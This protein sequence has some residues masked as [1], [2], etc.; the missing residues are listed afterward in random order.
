M[1]TNF[2]TESVLWE[3]EGKLL[4]EMATTQKMANILNAFVL[5]LVTTIDHTPYLYL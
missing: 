3:S 5:F 4:N 2:A 1:E